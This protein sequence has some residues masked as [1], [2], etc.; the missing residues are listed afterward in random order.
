MNKLI[1]QQRYLPA[2]KYKYT[3]DT[4]AKIKYVELQNQRFSR[5]PT[6][7]PVYHKIV[8]Q[9][10]INATQLSSIKLTSTDQHFARFQVPFAFLNSSSSDYVGKQ[11]FDDLYDKKGNNESTQQERLKQIGLWLSDNEPVFADASNAV[12][13]KVTPP[14]DILRTSHEKMTPSKNVFRTEPA[15]HSEEVK[16]DDE[17]GHDYDDDGE[18]PS[19]TLKA[20]ACAEHGRHYCSYHEDYPSK[21]VTEV[22]RYYKW[23]LE[24]LFRELRQQVMPKLA[25]DNYGGLVCDSV[26]RV[27]RPGWAKNTDNRWVVAINNDRYEQFI[28]EVICRHGSGS[29]CNFIPP[30]YQATCQQR[31][32]TQKLLVIDPWNPYKGPFLSEFL[33]PSCCVCFIEQ[34]DSHYS[35]SSNEVLTKR[36]DV[37]SEL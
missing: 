16:G 37:K 36:S 28:S 2:A 25:N 30:C 10:H 4:D 31:Y 8:K 14:M 34:S 18:H 33:F 6:S 9:M 21:V 7:S 29:H 17:Y 32:N 22:T 23:P 27:V 19:G 13:M 15:L 24:K 5:L 20:P 3:S 35:A 12:E 11:I 1:Q 26:T